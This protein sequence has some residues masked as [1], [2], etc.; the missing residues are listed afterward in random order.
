M[1]T[2]ERLI[3]L[4]LYDPIEGRFVWRFSIK[5]HVKQGQLAGSWDTHGYWVI[6]LDGQ[7]YLAHRLAWLWVYGRW[8]TGELDHI[9]SRR[10]DN[11]INNLRQAT[12]SQ[13]RHNAPI[14]KN[15][16]NGFKGVT[17]LPSG[18]WM[19]QIQR[20]K[21]QHYLGTFATA[22]EAH[23]AYCKAAE[24]YFGEFARTR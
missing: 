3:E 22:K 7:N 13:Q 1:I 5:G 20:N 24:K 10:D 4:V 23:E 6:G 14:N 9:N 12:R 15:T 18:H 2:R 8:P 19:A 16:K 17:M 21:Q 11:R